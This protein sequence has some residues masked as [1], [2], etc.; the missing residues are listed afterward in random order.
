MISMKEVRGFIV[1]EQGQASIEYLLLVG[2]AMLAALIFAV[3][4]RKM[5]YDVLYRQYYENVNE[6]YNVVCRYVAENLDVADQ[7]DFC[8]E[9]IRRSQGS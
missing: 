5:S 2:A 3:S 4:Y 6:T 9:I 7:A 8:A 1:E